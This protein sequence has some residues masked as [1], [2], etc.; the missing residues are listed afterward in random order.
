VGGGNRAGEGNRG[1]G[2][3]WKQT[4]YVAFSYRAHMFITQETI[5]SDFLSI[6]VAA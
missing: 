3:K 2:S 4:I 1:R 6:F 5:I